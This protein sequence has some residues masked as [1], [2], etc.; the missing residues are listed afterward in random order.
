M[1]EWGLAPSNSAVRAGNAGAKVLSPFFH[2]LTVSHKLQYGE[3]SITSAATA[4][5]S[6]AV[7]AR[8]AG[9]LLS[10]VLV[11]L[12]RQPAAAAERGRRL[13]PATVSRSICSWLCLAVLTCAVPQSGNGGCALKAR[14]TATDAAVLLALSDLVCQRV[15]CSGY[16]RHASP[17]PASQHALGVDVA[18]AG[19]FPGAASWFAPA[20]ERARSGRDHD[21]PW[22]SCCRPTAII[23][24]SSACPPI[25]AQIRRKRFAQHAM[26]RRNDMR[27]HAAG[28]VGGG[29]SSRIGFRQHGTA[30]DVRLWPIRWPATWRP[31]LRGRGESAWAFGRPVYRFEIR[32][33]RSRRTQADD[34]RRT[35]AHSGRSRAPRGRRARALTKSRSATWPAPS[36]CCCCRSLCR[37]GRGRD[38]LAAGSVRRRAR[39]R[40]L[41]CQ[42]SDRRSAGVDQ[43]LCSA[44]PANL[45]AI[46]S[47]DWPSRRWP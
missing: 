3:A 44:K 47:S 13:A 9:T 18:G 46:G 32:R 14:W 20:A 23:N 19:L 29:S 7:H 15:P 34:T 11:A 31:W 25:A 38:P 5:E 41:A 33:R 21:R 12:V 39:R 24:T 42:R 36:V 30:G 1:K 40:A 22:P 43:C 17:R 10:A 26:L 37:P 16:G 45:S 28:S 27:L 2:F 6:Q 8:Y 4:A 35:L